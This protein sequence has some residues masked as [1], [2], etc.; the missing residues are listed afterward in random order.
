MHQCTSVMALPDTLTH[1]HTH[2]RTGRVWIPISYCWPA[3]QTLVDLFTYSYRET[4][5]HLAILFHEIPSPY[6]PLVWVVWWNGE[7]VCQ[8]SHAWVEF[9]VEPHESLEGFIK[10]LSWQVWSCEIL[11]VYVWS[12]VFVWKQCFAWTV[13]ISAPKLFLKMFDRFFFFFS[14]FRW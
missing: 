9:S 10:L 12:T 5:N 8:H 7:A 13:L 14:F 11:Q 6:S 1:T 2:T 3:L 4:V